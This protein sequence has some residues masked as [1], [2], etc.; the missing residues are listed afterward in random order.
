[1]K[2]LEFI[3]L[4]DAP[5]EKVWEIMLNEKYYREWTEIF[6]PGSHFVGSWSEGSKIHFLA[7]N[8]AGQMSGMVSRVKE[9]RPY[10]YISIEHLGFVENGKEDTSSEA[11]KNFAGAHENY[12][13]KDR[14]GN[15][16]LFVEMDTEDEYEEMFDNTWPKALQK[17]KEL[18]ESQAIKH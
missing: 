1:M 12:T 9:Y 4:I 16:E 3:I 14:V 13:L 2:K 8:K 18:T 10:D 6:S 5:R 15:T 17:L 11:V 7:P